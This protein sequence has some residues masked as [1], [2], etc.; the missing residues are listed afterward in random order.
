MSTQLTH[1]LKG[2]MSCQ[3]KSSKLGPMQLERFDAGLSIFFLLATSA[4]NEEDVV[5]KRSKPFKLRIRMKVVLR[6][7]RGS[8]WLDGN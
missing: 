6:C 3:K 7:D 8:K 5:R 1:L 4:E 2:I